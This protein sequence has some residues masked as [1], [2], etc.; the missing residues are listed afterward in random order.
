MPL[1]IACPD[2]PADLTEAQALAGRLQA[3]GVLVAGPVPCHM[4]VREVVRVA[5][6]AVLLLAPALGEPVQQT[7]TLLAGSAA[8]P[9]LLATAAAPPADLQPWL[10]LNLVAW[11]PAPPDPAA[12]AAALPLARARFARDQAQQQA[13][14]G[15]LARLDERKW[16]DR[17]KGVLMR[18]QQLSEDDA[19]ALLRTASMQANLRVG[20]VS[21]SLIEAAQAAEAI[22]R[23][24]QLRMLSQRHVKALALRAVA[25]GRVEDTL[26]ETAQRL[27]RHLDWLERLPLPPAVAALLAATRSA[28]AD[29]QHTAGP[30]AA[31]GAPRAGLAWPA[32]L[33]ETDALAEQLL[34][35]ADAL[36]GALE[37]TSGRRHLQVVNLSGRQR[38][39]AQRLAKQALLAGLLPAPQ[40]GMQAQAAARTVREFETALATLERAPLASDAIRAA[41]AQARGQWQRLLDG[42]RRSDGP[43]ASAARATLARESEALVTS[44]DELTSL[45]EHSMQVLLG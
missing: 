45:Y 39:L 21:R 43:D 34:E 38:M 23:A 10:D 29:L 9:V 15:A 35:R 31:P 20:E 40:A 18:A 41:L 16:V 28:W 37:A 12:V 11:L 36:T 1:L 7:L 4:L 17:A 8:K 33:A 42:L 26:A 27:Q 25:R 30:G 13:L 6:E 3:A 24:G 19:F 44:F 14:A 32:L 5:P 22:N 2:A